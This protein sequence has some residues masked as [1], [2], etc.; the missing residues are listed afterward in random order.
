MEKN[1]DE[2][3][4]NSMK[5]GLFANKA[6]LVALIYLVFSAIWI[7]TTDQLVY[8]I[9]NN[10]ETMTFFSKIKGIFF[11]VASAVLIYFLVDVQIKRFIAKDKAYNKV[12]E[13]NQLIYQ[14]VPIGILFLKNRR[15]LQANRFFCEMT[16]Y[17]ESEIVG[18]TMRFFYETQ[19]EF[20]RVGA[21]YQK[22]LDTKGTVTFESV[23]LHKNGSQIKLVLSLAPLDVKNLSKGVVATLSDITLL[24]Q[25][26]V[27][28]E[29]EQ[30]RFSSVI[31][32]MPMGIH[33]W[34][35]TP[36]GELVF[37]GYNHAADTIL[38][39]DH[40]AL[41]GRKILEAFPSFRDTRIPQVYYETA[42]TGKPW[43]NEQFDYKDDRIAGSF[44][45]FAFQTVPGSMGVI[46][47]EVSERVQ[48]RES[49]KRQKDLIEGIMMTSPVGIIVFNKKREAIFANKRALEI[50]RTSETGIRKMF[51]RPVQKFRFTCLDGTPIPKEETVFFRIK[52]DLKPCYDERYAVVWG[53]DD[54]VY[55][56]VSAIPRLDQDDGFDG[57]IIS[58]EDI[59]AAYLADLEKA[60]L[61]ERLATSQRLESVAQLAGGV[62]H[63]F[64]NLL[65][66]II[67]YS[68]YLLEQRDLFKD[69]SL[70]G[71]IADMLEAAQ[72]AKGLTQQLLAFGRKQALQ[73]HPMNINE[74]VEGLKGII[75]S[76]VREN[77]SV[78]YFLDEDLYTVK[79]DK[80]QVEQIILNLVL[81]A[82]DAI[83]KGGKI[84][85]ETKNSELGPEYAGDHPEVE[86]GNYATLIVSDNGAGMNEDIQKRVFEP[87]FTTKAVGEGTG[88]GLA[89]VYGIVKQ[90]K[91]YIWL[92]SEL[93]RGTTFK[94]YLKQD[95]EGEA[96]MESAKNPVKSAEGTGRILV[97]EDNE[98]IRGMLNRVLKKMGF[99]IFMAESEDDAI[100][101]AKSNKGRID[102]LLTDVVMPRMNGVE[103]YAEIGKS[104]PGI[105]VLYMSGYTDNVIAHNGIL[106]PQVNFIQK[107]FSMNDLFDKIMSIIPEKSAK[108]GKK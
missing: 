57:I 89:T 64:N 43:M 33:L 105:R 71:V 62:A 14:T 29:E 19:E 4:V 78:A 23:F 45:S 56:S 50:F 66:P 21:Y 1:C 86:A 3:S 22:I 41:L 93:N 26:T 17:T 67:G 28:L 18:R 73:V 31:Q 81:N 106:D 55:I 9:S 103:L 47:N 83:S 68:D 34:K 32:S 61:E 58:I 60:R 25:F 95:I 7:L 96:I 72:K 35:V 77:I 20:I 2:V 63:D 13:Q 5:K 70:S 97:V 40:S 88:L 49:L 82:Q 92:Y 39:I 27:K 38:G 101:I 42:I 90:H 80:V 16:G 76:T 65:T 11:I 87:F 48:A 99:E 69:P 15:I 108:R 104:V 59:T 75:R 94:V 52:R 85:I 74:A 6:L 100:S 37:D 79:A 98:K 53:G 24:K 36:N 30:K 8:V 102:L 46:F 12:Y 10:P 91:G 107:P 44:E 84:V 54:T 51:L